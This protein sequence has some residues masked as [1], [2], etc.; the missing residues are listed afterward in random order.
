MYGL[1]VNIVKWHSI[2]LTE[3]VLENLHLV[4]IFSEEAADADYSQQD[5]L[6]HL[7]YI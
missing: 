3:S 5:L 4:Y 1:K 7:L 2:P 6:D